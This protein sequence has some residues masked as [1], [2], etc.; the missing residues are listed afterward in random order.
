MEIPQHQYPSIVMKY[1]ETK[2]MKPSHFYKNLCI[3]AKRFQSV[4]S[5][6][7]LML[8]LTLL[9]LTNTTA[10]VFPVTATPQ[11]IPPYSLKLSEYSTSF[12]EKLQLNLL[13]TDVTESNRQV[14]L[15]LYIENNAGIAIQSTD[16]V[17]GATPILLDGGSPL[18]LTNIDLQAYFALQNLQGISPQL[19]GTSLPEGLYQFCFEVYDFF[20]GRQISRKSCTNVYLVL[21]DPPFLNLPTRGE[22]VLIR[23]PQNIIFQW[24]PRHLNAT[25]VTYEFTLAEIWD[26]QMDPQAAFLAS[27]PIYQ[28]TTFA[29]TL[30]YGPT[31]TL[32]LPDK[33]Y[34]WRVRAMVSDGIS[35]TSVFKNNGYSEIYHFTHTGVC[36]EPQ[37]ILAESKIPTSQKILWQGV[38]HL[39]YKIQY[40]KKNNSSPSGGGREGVWFEGETQNEFTTIHQLEPG[41]TYSFRVGGQCMD[42]GGYTYS[43]IYEFTTPLTATETATYNCGITPEI[44]ITNQD[45]LP[46]L[47]Q[48][49]IFTAGDFPVTIMEISES[50]GSSASGWGYIVVPYLL[51]TKLKVIFSSIQINTDYQLM[52]GIVETDY[53]PDWGGMVDITDTIEL[54]LSLEEAFVQAL[55]LDIN[56]DSKKKIKAIA[57]AMT[58]GIKNE[59]LP[60][61]LKKEVDEV[62]SRLDDA[63]TSYDE[64]EEELKKASTPEEKEKAEKKKEQAENQFKEAQQQVAAVQDKIEKFVKQSFDIIKEAM[65]EII[66]D[67]NDTKVAFE[68]ELVKNQEKLPTSDYELNTNITSTTNTSTSNTE[69]AGIESLTE[70]TMLSETEKE[71]IVEYYLSQIKFNRIIVAK[72]FVEELNTA[73]GYKQLAIELSKDTKQL[74]TYINEELEKGILSKKELIQEVKK[75]IYQR[76]ETIL[77]NEIYNYEVAN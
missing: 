67:Y 24:T 6:F 34:A 25:N 41:T 38:D 73:E 50:N 30:L 48:G 71:Q 2:N 5:S 69:I 18:R 72:V 59:N 53:D 65:Y 8:I 31:E 12:S 58:N 28:T 3:L 1:K 75:V 42:T 10:Q 68:G 35:E 43:Q 49:D 19:Y 61:D 15:K 56:R 55:N 54:F 7:R 26:T 29:T 40:R 9:C 66:R 20:S 39:R 27:R 4:A 64:S 37:Y 23:E 14:R 47:I 70:T 33:N 62:A 74:A 16:A 36:P 76:I 21:N 44:R 57:Q 32:L 11:M 13:L 17:I 46:E 51:N 45:P 63:K 52:G 22:Q 77:F 60:E